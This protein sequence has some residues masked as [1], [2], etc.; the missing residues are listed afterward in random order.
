MKK[1]PSPPQMDKAE[2]QKALNAIETYINPPKS[3]EGGTAG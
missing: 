2:A 3:D 1:R